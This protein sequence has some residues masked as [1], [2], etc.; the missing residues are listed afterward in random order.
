MDKPIKDLGAP[1]PELKNSPI[2]DESD[3]EFEVL[4]QELEENVCYFNAQSFADGA[5]IQSGGT[6]LRCDK[7]I[8]VQTGPDEPE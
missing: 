1:D 2:S 7:G 4:R 6:Y 5:Y 8:W 3:E